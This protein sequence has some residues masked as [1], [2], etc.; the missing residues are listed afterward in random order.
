MESQSYLRVFRNCHFFKIIPD[1]DG[2]VIHTLG[3]YVVVFS[4]THPE[5]YQEIQSEGVFVGFDSNKDFVLQ[6]R[7]NQTLKKVQLEESIF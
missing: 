4:L 6:L 3:K 2:V 1:T 7:E 5:C